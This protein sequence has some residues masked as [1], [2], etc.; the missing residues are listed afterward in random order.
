MKSPKR[1]FLFFFFFLNSFFLSFSQPV[2]SLKKVLK[3]AKEDTVKVNT[4]SA[5]AWELQLIDKFDESLPYIK[6][7]I[8]LGKK[9]KHKRELALLYRRS[10]DYYNFTGDYVESRKEYSNALDIETV[11]RNKSKM[12]VCY[13]KIAL[14]LVTTKQYSKAISN[15]NDGLYLYENMRDTASAVDILFSIWE[16]QYKKMQD[17]V[18]AA[19]T[20]NKVEKLVS[21]SGTDSLHAILY[22]KVGSFYSK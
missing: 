7:G 10:G 3:N 6:E 16:V 19:E 1:Y 22:N 15:Y 14:L 20:L 8:L 12:A 13:K 2:D 18:L 11:L 4:L 5:L 17:L 9:L 21:R